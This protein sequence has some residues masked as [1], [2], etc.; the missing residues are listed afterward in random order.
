MS[1]W[2]LKLFVNW[3]FLNVNEPGEHETHEAG[4]GWF[5]ATLVTCGP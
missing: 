5:G 4:I 1:K 2:K 3:F